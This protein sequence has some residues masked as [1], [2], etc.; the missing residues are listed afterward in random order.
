M[1]CL[2]Q[3]IHL[4]I[5]L[6]NIIIITMTKKLRLPKSIFTG[7]LP[8]YEELTTRVSF[9]VWEQYLFAR[10]DPSKKFSKLATAVSQ[11]VSTVGVGWT[12]ANNGNG[13]RMKYV[14]YIL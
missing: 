3:K 11:L 4:K 10:V 12:L 1:N 9:N 2:K 13:F 8:V 7:V 6:G 5:K 14:E